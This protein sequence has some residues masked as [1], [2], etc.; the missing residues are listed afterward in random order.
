ML[1]RLRSSSPARLALCLASF[2]AV[3]GAFG[4]HPEQPLRASDAPE[5]SEISR[6]ATQAVPH[7]CPACLA[8]GAGLLLPLGGFALVPAV[9]APAARAEAPSLFDRLAG[10]DLSGRSPPDRS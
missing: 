8:H 2:L 10:R 4:L 7:A 1:R 5:A 6:V 9:S 3:A